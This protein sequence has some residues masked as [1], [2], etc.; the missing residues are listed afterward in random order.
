MNCNWQIKQ[1]NKLSF[2]F[3]NLDE[4]ILC[5]YDDFMSKTSMHTLI[6]FSFCNDADVIG[7]N[8]VK[9]HICALFSSPSSFFDYIATSNTYE[10]FF[11]VLQN[12]Q[13][14]FSLP[15]HADTYLYLLLFRVL[16]PLCSFIRPVRLLSFSQW[17]IF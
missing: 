7:V 4:M 14:R 17:L 5:K 13:I 15:L 11:F 8:L 2:S 16:S 1:R 6:S 10:L 3:Y 9:Y 12:V